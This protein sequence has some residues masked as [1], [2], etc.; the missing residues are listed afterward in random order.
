MVVA[1]PGSKLSSD[2]DQLGPRHF[3][4]PPR[5]LLTNHI[6]EGPETEALGLQV[7]G[8]DAFTRAVAASE[9]NDHA[10]LIAHGRAGNGDRGIRVASRSLQRGINVGP[11][12]RPFGHAGRAG[13]TGAAR[14]RPRPAIFVAVSENVDFMR[15]DD[16]LSQEERL[17]RDSVRSF[18]EERVVP[19]IEDHF[20]KG[21]FPCIWWSPWPA[22]ATWGPA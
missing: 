22:S 19:I 11:G 5:D 4:P 13:P 16:L 8:H 12:S 14:L 2:T 10:I 15:L 18:V 20:R 17:I 9:A 7:V 6:G 21:T 3:L 1:V